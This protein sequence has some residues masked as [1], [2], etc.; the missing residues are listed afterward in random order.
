MSNKTLELTV[1]IAENLCGVGSQINKTL[2]ALKT[3]ANEY[4]SDNL[5]GATLYY[6]NF[7]EELDILLDNMRLF[8]LDA[9]MRDIAIHNQ[10]LDEKEVKDNEY[11]TGEED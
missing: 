11:G 8:R 5:A 10:L 3:F 9:L 1:G 4:I 7:R 6:G 2:N